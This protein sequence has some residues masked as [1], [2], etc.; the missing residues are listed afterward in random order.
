VY[1]PAGTGVV[2]ERSRLLR[3]LLKTGDAKFM[4]KYAM[5][6]R[7]QAAASPLLADFFDATDVLVPVPGCAPYIAG[8]VWAAEHLAAALVNEGLGRATWSGLRRV[9]A[10]RKSATA[11]PGARPSVSLHYDSFCIETPPIPPESI[12]LIDDVITKGRTLLAA[13]SRVREAIPHAKIRAFALVRTMGMISGIQQL[14]DPCQ[15]E[16]RWKSGDAYRN[17]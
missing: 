17:P 3:T 2:C 14:L 6:V 16:I 15:G 10:V 9:R 4:L 5:R 7:Q 13:A 11:A 12:V 8:H 1:S